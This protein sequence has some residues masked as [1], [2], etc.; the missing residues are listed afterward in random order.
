[1]D[2]SVIKKRVHCEYYHSSI[3]CKVAS[4]PPEH[5]ESFQIVLDALL[6]LAVRKVECR[7]TQLYF[8]QQPARSSSYVPSL[9]YIALHTYITGNGLRKI[10][11]AYPQGPSPGLDL[12][13][14]GEHFVASLPSVL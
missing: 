6:I 11:V 2:V 8:P 9:P 1:M 3:N 4:I 7:E 12:D 5:K 14:E 13:L 10:K